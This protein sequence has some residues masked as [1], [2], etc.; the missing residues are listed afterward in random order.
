MTL[1]C[2]LALSLLLYETLD[3]AL[4]LTELQFLQIVEVVEK[5]NVHE[6]FTKRKLENQCQR[7]VQNTKCLADIKSYPAAIPEHL[8]L[9]NNLNSKGVRGCDCSCMIVILFWYQY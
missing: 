9:M 7:T 5:N 4:K 6:I 3:K 2:I 1:V 8:Y